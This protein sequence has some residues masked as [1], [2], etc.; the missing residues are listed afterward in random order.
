MEKKNGGADTELSMTLRDWFAGH[1][2]VS[3][4]FPLLDEDV[5]AELAG[6]PQPD[7]NEDSVGV[8]KWRLKVLAALRYMDADAMIAARDEDRLIAGAG[9]A[10]VAVCGMERKA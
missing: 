2:N 10:V 6:S 4:N 5:G 7:G 3:L 8:I 1:S 9:V